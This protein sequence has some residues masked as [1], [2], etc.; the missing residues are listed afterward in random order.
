MWGWANGGPTSD[1]VACGHHDDFKAYMD[2]LDKETFVACLDIGHAEL[3]G[4]NTSTTEML[5]TLGNYVQAI[6][7]HDNYKAGGRKE[8]VPCD[9][10]QLPFTQGVDFQK[11]IDGLKKIGYKGDITMEADSFI[12]N[13]PPEL[14][15]QAGR[16]MADVAKYFKDKIE[17]E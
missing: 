5:E 4:M 14:V 9:T 15:W 17:K 2:A 8:G 12:L 1:G 11:V 16:F 13:M 7:L 3:S 10:H 6:H